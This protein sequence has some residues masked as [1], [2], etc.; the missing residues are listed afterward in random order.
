[1]F[2]L[3]FIVLGLKGEVMLWSLLSYGLDLLSCLICLIGQ[4]LKASGLT[5]MSMG[6]HVCGR[7]LLEGP[8]GH[9]IRT[10]PA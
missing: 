8:L 3:F 4:S 6:G 7:P 10:R 2:S 9:V 5:P 1:M